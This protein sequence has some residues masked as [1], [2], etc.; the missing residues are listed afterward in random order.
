MASIVSQP[1]VSFSLVS[2]DSEVANA[3]QRVLV[4]GSYITGDKDA[5]VSAGDWIQ[6]LGNAGEENA[7]FGRTSHLAGMIR[8][9]KRVAPQVQLDC[10]ALGPGATARV[11][12]FVVSGSGATESG[13]ITLTIGSER[14]HTISVSIAKGDTSGD[15][16]TAAVAAINLDIECQWTAS[17]VTTNTIRLTADNLGAITDNDAFGVSGSIAGITVAAPTET[18]GAGAEPTLGAS[19]FDVIGETRYQAIIFPFAVRTRLTD[20]L[21]ARFNVT[22]AVRDGVGFSM[23][24]QTKANAVTELASLNS[25]SLVVFYDE[26]QTEATYI[27]GAIAEPPSILLA[28]FTASITI[29][30]ILITSTFLDSVNLS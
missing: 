28:Y 20:L 3:A 21:D 12:D 5:S 19:L 1:S 10:I 4:V 26:P 30:P 17:V 29:S 22:N 14:N 24:H 18:T 13:A 23:S 11:V 9:F 7:L 8:A 15:V 25:Q 2:A 27:G 16:A 6:K